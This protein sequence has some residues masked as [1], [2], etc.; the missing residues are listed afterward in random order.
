MLLRLLLI[1]LC[2]VSGL[3]FGTTVLGV[4]LLML[5]LLVLLLQQQLLLMELGQLLRHG[6]KFARNLIGA[7]EGGE[8]LFRDS[9][10][11]LRQILEWK[12]RYNGMRGERFF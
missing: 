4:R 6:S 9:A 8:L 11:R 12:F 10:R 3:C 7:E 2:S 1:V 5:L